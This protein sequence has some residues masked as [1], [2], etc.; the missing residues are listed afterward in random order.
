VPGIAFAPILTIS[1][2]IQ[3]PQVLEMNYIVEYDHPSM[4]RIKTFGYPM[5]F[6]E[7]PMSIKS[8]PPEHGEH[9]EFVLLEI[10]GYSWEEIAQ[11]REEGVI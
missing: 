2:V 1:E 5:E 6:S 11:F 3:D 8:R 4:G 9:T 10:G 7:T